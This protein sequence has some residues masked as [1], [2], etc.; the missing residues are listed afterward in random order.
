MESTAG[1]EITA[2]FG[3]PSPSLQ[4]CWR[5]VVGLAADRSRL[6]AADAGQSTCCSCSDI[7]QL[8]AEQPAALSRHHTAPA[9]LCTVSAIPL[10]SSYQVS[11]VTNILIHL[12]PLHWLHWTIK[13]CEIFSTALHDYK[14]YYPELI[15]CPTI[16]RFEF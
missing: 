3:S 4:Q 5:V 11:K 8:R 6:S 13:K 10:V 9:L 1:H 16:T 7:S 2:E 15:Q 14:R 12:T